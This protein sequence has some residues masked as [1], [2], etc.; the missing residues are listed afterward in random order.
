MR[1]ILLIAIAAVGCSYV[2]FAQTGRGRTPAATAAVAFDP[3]DL[4][5]IWLGRNRA[6]ALSDE[7]PP[8]TPWGEAKFNSYKPSY[9]PRAIPPA[10][11]TARSSAPLAR[12]TPV[13]NDRS[14][15][16]ASVSGSCEDYKLTAIRAF[17]GSLDTGSPPR[18]QG[19]RQGNVTN[20]N[21]AVRAIGEAPHRF[22]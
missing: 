6:L 18:L 2:T 22:R 20:N 4:S 21:A 10:R 17:V 14:A 3:H 13:L 8:R 9:G 11:K 19:R 1:R 7:P 5:G 12:W 16:K 15:R